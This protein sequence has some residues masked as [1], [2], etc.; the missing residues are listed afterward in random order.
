MCRAL[1]DS[2]KQKRS[3]ALDIKQYSVSRS[4]VLNFFKTCKEDD[5]FPARMCVVQASHPGMGRIV[6][7]V[8][9]KQAFLE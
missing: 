7:C 9:G 8:L 2:I 3:L 6:L 1:S 5:K 4:K